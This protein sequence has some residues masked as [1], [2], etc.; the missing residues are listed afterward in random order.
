MTTQR[1]I[2]SEVYSRVCGY[3]RPVQQWNRGKQEEFA[4][5]AE[6]RIPSRKKYTTPEER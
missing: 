5:R 3:F 4:Q 2:P 1:K 6:A